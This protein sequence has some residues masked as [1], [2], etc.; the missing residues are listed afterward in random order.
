VKLDLLERLARPMPVDMQ[1]QDVPVSTIL[2][3]MS[4]VAGLEITADETAGEQAGHAHGQRPGRS[5]TLSR[6]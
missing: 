2:R 3:A 6:P 4:D 1:F 5:R